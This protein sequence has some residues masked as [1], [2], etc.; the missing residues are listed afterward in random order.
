MADLS[1]Q[2]VQRAVQDGTR[3]LQSDVQRLSN[4]MSSVVPQAQLIDDLQRALQQLQSEIQR[5]DPRSEA[6]MQQLVRDVQELKIRF[7]AVE[8]F[9]REMSEYF[10]ARA[11]AER[12]DNEYRGVT[13]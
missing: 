7:E 1:Y 10:R 4:D 13:P 2:D 8:R 11:A 3:N 5:H 9:C 12:E 6:S